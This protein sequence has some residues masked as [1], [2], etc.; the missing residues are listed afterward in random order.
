MQTVPDDPYRV[1]A[2]W[3][4]DG[5]YDEDE[6]LGATP[7]SLRLWLKREQEESCLAY[8]SWKAQQ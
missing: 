4:L 7:L 1:A 8:E 6:W 3:E 5:D 2:P